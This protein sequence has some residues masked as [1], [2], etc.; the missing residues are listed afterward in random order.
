MT[1][2]IINVTMVNFVTRAT[3]V[4]VAGVVMITNITNNFLV[5]IFTWLKNLRMFLWFPVPP[6][7]PWLTVVV[8]SYG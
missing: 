3:N 5:T 2:S 8:G 6:W 7:L 4:V 1:S